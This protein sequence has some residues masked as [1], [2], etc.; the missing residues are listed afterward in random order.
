MW[1]LLLC[2][3][4]KDCSCSSRK[5]TAPSSSP[6]ITIKRDKQ[7]I[8]PLISHAEQLPLIYDAKH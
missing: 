4:I 6:A 5:D 7:Q 1:F 2:Y 8:P 3:H